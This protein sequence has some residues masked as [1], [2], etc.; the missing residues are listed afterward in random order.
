M[1][2]YQNVGFGIDRDVIKVGG[3]IGKFDRLRLRVLGNDV[4]LNTLKVVYMDGTE[5]DLAVDADIRANTRTSWLEVQGD[6][7]ISA[8]SR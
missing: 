2:G 5:Q 3:E 4:H 6:K 8:K 7:F 1:F